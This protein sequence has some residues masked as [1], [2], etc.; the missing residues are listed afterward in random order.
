MAMIL[1]DDAPE[2][3]SEFIAGSKGF[4]FLREDEL[5]CL[6]YLYGKRGGINGKGEIEEASNL[7]HRTASQLGQDIDIY[8][9]SSSGKL[10][11]EYIRSK[12]I[13][14][15]LQLTV[16]KKNAAGRISSDPATL[17][18]CFAQHAAY[19]RQAYFFGLYGPLKETELMSD[20]RPALT[21]R[22]V[23]VCY[24]RKSAKDTGL[25][26]PLIPVYMWF[27]DQAGAKP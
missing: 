11:S 10:D 2:R 17:S 23:M 20:I 19:Y 12:I 15:Q 6:M 16:E 3:L 5:M 24:N 21:G 22:M 27:R 26:H 9:N 18:H 4:P 8:L 1:P 7:A 25:A 13:N 14:R